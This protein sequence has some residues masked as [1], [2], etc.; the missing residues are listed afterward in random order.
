MTDKFM[1]WCMGIE[2]EWVGFSVWFSTLAIGMI[3]SSILIVLTT[4][5]TSGWIL[6]AIPAFIVYVWY[7][8]LFKQ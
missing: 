4:Y 3:F 5:I 8:A 7:I 1:E 2:P 6:L